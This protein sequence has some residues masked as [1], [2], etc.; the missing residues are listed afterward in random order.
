MLILSDIF[1]IIV[2]LY[3]FFISFNLDKIPFSVVLIV[4]R[5][6]ENLKIVVLI[7]PKKCYYLAES[8]EIKIC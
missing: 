5:Q 2:V 7:C 8:H 3:C 4:G 1:Q 6:L